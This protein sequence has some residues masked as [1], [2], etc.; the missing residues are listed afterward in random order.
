[1]FLL[2]GTPG[3]R[4]G[5]RSRGIVHYRLDVRLISYDRPGYPGS[6][7]LLGSKAADTAEDVK[8]IADYFGIDRFSIVGRSGGA[9]HA[10]A[11]AA[12]LKDRVIC[13]VALGSLPQRLTMCK[14]WDWSAGMADSNIR[15]YREAEADLAAL[16]ATLKNQ[17]KPV[18]NNS[19]GLLKLLWPEIAGHDKEVIG[20]IALRRIIAQVHAEALGDGTA[21]GWI[22]DV[23]A[24]SRPWGFELSDIAVP[25]KLWSG[26]DDV[27]SR[28]SVYP[29]VLRVTRCE[30]GAAGE[31]R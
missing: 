12:L 20:D 17:V 31:G 23:I 10:L 5:P 2:H 7:R 11:C 18:R 30:A 6:D 27:F 15:T 28:L 21:D 16:I 19:E 8:A 26:S 22:D 9:P 29:E 14:A 1:M 24:L 13:A 4:N 25:V 3:S